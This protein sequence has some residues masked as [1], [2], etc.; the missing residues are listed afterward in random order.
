MNSQ[1]IATLDLNSRGAESPQLIDSR[2]EQAPELIIGGGAGC[3]HRD[4]DAASVVRLAHHPRREFGAA[5]PRE[6]QMAV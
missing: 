3:R 5:V 2:G 1:P 6:D 4:A